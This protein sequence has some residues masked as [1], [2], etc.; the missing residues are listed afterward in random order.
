MTTSVTLER[1]GKNLK[2]IVMGRD[3]AGQPWLRT[4][5]F[6]QTAAGL[7]E[8]R[9]YRDKT[10]LSLVVAA[11]DGDEDDDAKWNR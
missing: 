1:E 9:A 7:A 4:K 11:I 3:K 5:R 2:V 6:P 10:A 8:A